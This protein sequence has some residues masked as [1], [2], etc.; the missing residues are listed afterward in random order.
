VNAPYRITNVFAL[1]LLAAP[2]SFIACS[3]SAPAPAAEKG[4]EKLTVG[5]LA[6]AT[7]GQFQPVGLPDPG[8]PGYKF[9]EDED[10]IVAWTKINNQQAIDLHAWGLWT[11]LTKES[12]QVFNS[13]KLLVFETWDNPS[14]LSPT[15]PTA[16][17][18]R[19]RFPLRLTVPR[20]FQHGAA[21]QALFTAASQPGAVRVDVKF[22]PIAADFILANGLLSA[23]RLTSYL[24]TDHKTAVPGFPNTAISLKP[25]YRT[26]KP[27]VG[28]RYY[29]LKVW[30]GAPP[31]IFNQTS[32]LWESK[33]FP[34][35]VW[36]QCVWIDIQ[37][38]GNAGAGVDKTCA[39][40]GSSRTSANTYGIDQFIHFQMSQTDA[41][42]INAEASG[43]TSVSAGDY[44]ILVGMH[45]TSREITRWTWQTFWWV[46]DPDNPAAP[47]SRTIASRRPAQLAGASR[48]YAQCTGYDEEVPSQPN[49]GGSNTGETIYCYNP[50]LEAR[51][52][53]DVLPDSQPGDT[54]LNG[55]TVKTANNVGVQTNCMS[56]HGRANY[57]PGNVATAPQYSGARYVDLNDPVFNGVLK[58]D[59]LW[60]LAD[61]AK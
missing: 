60:S 6:K 39:A 2:L 11:A 20:Q 58:V 21:S 43:A 29:L 10:S 50:Y 25:T 61:N 45:V 51:F 40:D 19:I 7:A 59:F 31:L 53:P 18:T 5:A 8:I 42:Q 32:K 9:P 14:D 22:D 41:D 55:K 56:C 4:P 38:S 33:A 34:D 17:G 15:P 54:Q 47:S 16:A 1:L 30:P 37:G 48:H 35:S 23:A 24:N 13:Q 3:R 26:L 36:G 46:N 52:T 28:D 49:S 44:A 57:N 12:D 27:L